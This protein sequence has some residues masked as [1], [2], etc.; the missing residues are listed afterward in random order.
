MATKYLI[1]KSGVTLYSK[2]VKDSE[3]WADDVQAITVDPATDFLYP[4]DTDHP[5]VYVQAGASPDA[6]DEFLIDAREAYYG[7]LET[8]D[9][10]F[11]RRI[12]SWDWDNASTVEK[13][14]GLYA[15]TEAI[16]KFCFVGDKT[17][18]DQL[19]EFPRTR[20][21]T[22]ANET[23]YEIGGTAG[24]PTAIETAAYLIAEAL[25][26]G[27]D[28]DAEFEAQNVRVETFG[29]V[30]TEFDT[31]KGPQGHVSN[32]IPSATAWTFIRPFVEISRTFLVN[33][34]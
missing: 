11:N 12:H 22:D 32:L 26:S 23:V 20:T 17:D 8:G 2:T 10:Y 14:Q 7:D 29:P 27:R 30:R 13:V 3:P 19:L 6:S 4:V 33:K 1:H 9:V 24:V 18:S 21:G 5:F 28:P 15:A 25:I 34:A 16:D 31:D